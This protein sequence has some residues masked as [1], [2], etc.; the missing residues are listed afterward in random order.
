[1][2]MGIDYI[3]LIFTYRNR[4]FHAHAKDAYVDKTKYQYYG[5]FNRQLDRELTNGYWEYRIPGRGQVDFESMIKALNLIGYQGPL[6]IEHEDL[7]YEGTDE[8]VSEGLLCARE[9][10]ERVIES[11]C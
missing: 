4:I 3:P 6:S 5:T 7:H 10:L 11:C 8:K 1:M 9:Y 2:I